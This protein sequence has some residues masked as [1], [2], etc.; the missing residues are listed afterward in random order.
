MFT[1]FALIV[2][3]FLIWFLMAAPLGRRAVGATVQID[4]PAGR[5]W[6]AL[7]PFGRHANWNKALTRVIAGD[8]LEY[9]PDDPDIASGRMIT[10]HVGRDGTPIERD[11]ALDAV[12]A[13]HRFRLRYTSDSA[14]D[15]SHWHDHHMD[16][17]IT[18]MGA[19]R[20]RV[21][22]TETDIYKGGAFF[23]FRYFA[24]RRMTSKL[25]IWAEQGTFVAGGLFEK[26][27]TQVGLA[28]LSAVLLWPLFGLT[29]MGLFLAV[30]LTAVVALH[31][32]G[33]MAAF[34]LMGHRTARMI[35][36]PVL[37]GIALGGRP[38][39]TRF[40]VGFAALMGAGFSAFLSVALMGAHAAAVSA[41]TVPNTHLIVFAAMMC[42]FFNLGNLAP[43]WKFD[44]GQIIRQLFSSRLGQG[45]AAS[46]MLICLIALGLELGLPFGMLLVS[47]AVIL[48]LSLMTAGGGVRPKRPLTPMSGIERFA[49]A[50][51]LVAVSAI[52]ATV[53]LWSVQTL[54]GG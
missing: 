32:L 4:A 19:M 16:V 13:P 52:H 54:I 28:A 26:P 21:T 40:E 9:D 5:V 8:A 45:V 22:V 36:I 15:Q 7:Y 35:F 39:D 53:L 34:R 47:A 24:L 11:F 17:S 29:A 27:A 20:C 46:T 42:A 1:V 2:T 30:T 12:A 3:V 51:A 49:L 10:T 44:G 50:A 31:E 33:H 41:S 37:G 23:V 25:K 38:Y 18:E 6:Q 48:T 43:V 14:L